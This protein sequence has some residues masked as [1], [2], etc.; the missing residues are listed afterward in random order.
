MS[1]LCLRK[2]ACTVQKKK[3]WN[4]NNEYFLYVWNVVIWNWHQK[5]TIFYFEFISID[6]HSILDNLIAFFKFSSWNNSLLFKKQLHSETPLSSNKR[7][8]PETWGMWGFD[9]KKFFISWQPETPSYASRADLKVHKK[10]T[11]Q[12]P[13]KQL[14]RDGFRSCARS[15]IQL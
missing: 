1:L 14:E 8:R 9:K 11:K 3:I 12:Q 7:R 5:C 4:R 15:I 10:K 2:E 6:T 13:R